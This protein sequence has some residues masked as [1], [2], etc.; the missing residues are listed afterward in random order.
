MLIYCMYRISRDDECSI[1]FSQRTS[2]TISET[3]EKLK[4]RAESGAS[5]HDAD[6]EYVQ[7]DDWKHQKKHIFVLSQSGKP[8]YSRYGSELLALV[9][10]YYIFIAGNNNSYMSASVLDI[11]GLFTNQKGPNFVIILMP[12]LSPFDE[13]YFM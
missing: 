8:I 4:V 10:I 2:S 5:D 13:N 1:L 3:L 11:V 12:K 7:S 9:H 6:L